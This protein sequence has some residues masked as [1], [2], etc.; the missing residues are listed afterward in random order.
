MG[1]NK[2][3]LV[4]VFILIGIFLLIAFGAF[5]FMRFQQFQPDDSVVTVSYDFQTAT[6]FIHSCAERKANE[7][8]VRISDQGGS[9]LLTENYY[10]HPF[11]PVAYHYMDGENMAYSPEEV[12][13]ELSKFMDEKVIGCIDEANNVQKNVL[14][15][16]DGE[17]E[18]RT[19]INENSVEFDV[20]FP[21]KMDM[22]NNHHKESMFVVEI[23]NLRLIKI[24]ELSWRLAKEQGEH[25]ESLCYSCIYKLA[26]ENNM[27]IDYTKIGDDVIYY[28][29]TDLTSRIDGLPLTFSLAHKN[30]I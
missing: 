13:E 4:T 26:E 18:T 15:S 23:E 3:G 12:S 20:K 19:T 6:S 29:I 30:G 21:L 16:Q 8:L 5:F 1:L 22:G 14:V 24:L 7:A 28:F 10:D 11:F 27:R 17:P 9:Y 2:K 25:K